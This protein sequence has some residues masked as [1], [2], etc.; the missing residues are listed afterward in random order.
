MVSKLLA[1]RLKGCLA[2][3]VSEEQSAFQEGRSILDNAL[4]AIEV[5]HALKRKTRGRK[6]SLALKIDISKAYDRVD[7]GFLRGM[8]E[9][10]GFAN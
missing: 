2:K 1:N 5:V 6:G 9:R 3:C 10:L 8:L 7:W 4:I